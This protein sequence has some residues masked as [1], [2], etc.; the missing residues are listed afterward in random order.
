LNQLSFLGTGSFIVR[1][2]LLYFCDFTLLAGVLF[3]ALWLRSDRRGN[4]AAVYMI[5]G[6]GLPWVLFFS[7]MRNY[8]ALHPFPLV[9]GAPFLAI[10][11]GYILS[12]IWQFLHREEPT[13][14]RYLLYAM[15]VVLPLLVLYPVFTTVQQAK[16]PFGAAEFQDFSDVIRDNT[17][18]DS[19]TLSPSESAVPIYYS[20]R[21]IV[22]GI[23]TP[24]LLHLAIPQARVDFPGSRLFF[25]L[26]DK[27]RPPFYKAL[28]G[29]VVV[30]RQGDSTLYSVP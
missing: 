9:L 18:P 19:V 4:V 16:T 25:A 26:Q 2:L 7:L 11:S 29:F 1:W 6:L 14:P 23:E 13:G 10:A 8:V 20:D 12:R 22:R 17:S 15:I 30:A 21:H 24:E 28:P 27:D 3:L 5:G